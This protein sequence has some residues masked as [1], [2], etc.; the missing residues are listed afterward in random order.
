MQMLRVRDKSWDFRGETAKIGIHGIHTYP[1]MMLPQIARRLI[2]K[3]G[4]DKKTILDPFC[5]SGTVL[6]EGILNN[7]NVFGYDIN[8]LAVLISKVKITPLDVDNLLSEAEKLESELTNALFNPKI[9]EDVKTPRF[10]N[11][12]YW[13]KPNV[14]RELAY[15]KSLIDEIEDENYKNF[16]LVAFSE[17]VR[18]SSNTRD[19]EYKLFRI[20]KHKLKSWNPNAIAI[21]LEILDRN[22]KLAVE[23]YSSKPI[24]RLKDGKINADIYLSDVRNRIDVEADM[25]VTSPP[26]GDSRTTVAYGQFSRLSLQWLDFDYDTIKSIDKISLGGVRAKRILSDVNSQTL[27]EILDQIRKKDEKRALDVYSFFKDFQKAS[28]KI[29]DALTDKSIIAL[30]VGN[31]T[32]CKISIPTDII[33]SEIFQSLGYRHVETIIREIPSKRLPRKSSPS[34][35]R[36]DKVE[37]MNKEFIVILG[38]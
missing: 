6:V 31:R 36:G 13:F 25:V 35:V 1:A 27:Y 37:T 14:I 7:R 29:V 8:P 5:G 4:K 21:F 26:Y 12:D 19:S 20:P 28:E 9:L 18:K 16:F 17:A 33:M 11:I 2:E 3:F 15:I 30:V 23:Y 32:V 22:L 10:F 38:D 34:N 24:E